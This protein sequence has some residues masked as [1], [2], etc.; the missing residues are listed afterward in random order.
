MDI[1][2]EAWIIATSHQFAWWLMQ[3]EEE[4]DEFTK[5]AHF[6]GECGRIYQWS[7]DD[8]AW[9]YEKPFM[10]CGH[11]WKFLDKPLPVVVM[12]DPVTHTDERPFCMD[13][14]CPCHTDSALIYEHVPPS[15]LLNGLMTSEELERFFY[16][17]QV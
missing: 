11:S 7:A 5:G 9:E 8:I 3:E 2:T 15:H 10:P 6:C 13:P 14:A 1:D 12:L 16:G 4:M 17:R